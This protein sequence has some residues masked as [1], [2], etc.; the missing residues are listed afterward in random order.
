MTTTE[1]APQP[2][3]S[4]S[5]VQRVWPAPPAP[6]RGATAAAAAVAGAVAALALPD[7][8]VGIGIVVVGVAVGAAAVLQRRRPWAGQEL[9]LG[10]LAGALLGVA[11]VRDAPWLVALCLLASVGLGALAS[12]HAR[13]WASGLLTPVAAATAGLRV[14]PWVA[15][16][17][18][19]LLGDARRW[20]SVVR[21]VAVTSL[22]LLVFG[23]LLASADA[24]FARLVDAVT[25]HVDLGELPGRLVVGVVVSGVALT[26]AYLA[27]SPPPWH[28]VRVPAGRSLPR[29]E[30]LVPVGALDLLLL[31][32]LAVQSAVLFGGREHVLRTSGLTSA[33]YARSGF[34]Q[35]L[36]VTALVLGVVAAAVHWAPRADAADRLVVRAALGLLLV[37]TLAVAGSA[38]L[39]M[40]LYDAAFGATRA[41]LFAVA[42]ELWVVVVLLLVGWAGTRWPDG[43]RRWARDG[44]FRAVVGSGGVVLLVLAVVDADALIAKRNVDRFLSG[45]QVDTAY[46]SEL[47]ADAVGELDRLPEP[48]RACALAPV[49]QRLAEHDDSAWAGANLSRQRARALLE[50]RPVS[51][52]ACPRDRAGYP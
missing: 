2:T 24:A 52:D 44:L 9:G 27:S 26:A 50:R 12:A 49:A 48:L 51:D 18:A 41:R 43:R 15:R 25:P 1:P 16:G 19:P 21:T 37:L 35:L 20:V 8:P 46:L 42:V 7:A 39:R 23:A 3:P 40:H 30:W 45:E 32:F 33:E 17:T 11:A 13:T 47:S 28:V 34:W 22:L 36:A 10:A 4:P 6:V 38:L 29:A 31:T 14:L 5:P